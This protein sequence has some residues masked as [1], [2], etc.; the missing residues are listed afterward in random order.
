[1][2]LGAVTLAPRYVALTTRKGADVRR[3]LPHRDL[4]MIGAWC[5][6]D[7]YGPT[8]DLDVMSIGAHPHIGLQTASW[9]FNGE[10]EHRD[11][12]GSVQRIAPGEL[13]LMTA[14]FGI[15]HSELSQLSKSG[16]EPLRGVQLW[17]ALPA[18]ARGMAP[19]FQH[20]VELPVSERNGFTFRTFIGNFGGEES[21]ARTFSELLGVE[22]STNL[23]AETTLRLSPKFE[24]G[25]LVDEGSIVINGSEVR[26]GELHYLPEGISEVSISTRASARLI[27]LGGEPFAE[28][29]LMWW[30]FI[31]S[32][33]EEIEQA[34]ANWQSAEQS[35]F[36]SFADAIND[37]IPAP[38]MPNLRLTT[39]GRQR[40]LLE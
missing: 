40:H 25:I 9:L 5:F 8:M 33:H 36:P 1:M 22:I 10:I 32:S 19:E 30:N 20:C 34:R 23:A 3:T 27:L 35:R 18:S 28:Q 7:H 17:I 26:S 39:R 15:A 6:I 11:S 2:T 14:G 21:P 37:R 4:F 16:S 31:A 29:I 38:E 13:N 12:L 24:H